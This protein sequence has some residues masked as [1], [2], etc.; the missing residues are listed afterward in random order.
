M[1]IRIFGCQLILPGDSFSSC[2]SWCLFIYSPLWLTKAL[3]WSTWASSLA[4]AGGL[5]VVA[6]AQLSSAPGQRLYQCFLLSCE[7]CSPHHPTGAQLLVGPASFGPR[8]QPEGPSNPVSTL[9]T[10]VQMRI[11]SDTH[12]VSSTLSFYIFSFCFSS[13]IGVYL[14]QVCVCGTGAPEPKLIPP[15]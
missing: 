11:P 9:C 15:S 1:C 2:L 12:V 14:E 5:P 13:V 10:S 4:S 3:I 6:T 7:H 8:V